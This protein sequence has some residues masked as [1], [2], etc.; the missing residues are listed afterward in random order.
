MRSTALW[1]ATRGTGVVALLL[2]TAVVLLG[3][4][5][6]FRWRS[7]RLPKFLVHGLHRNLTLLVLAFLAVHIVTAVVDT[8]A[9]IRIVDAVI[10][11][12]G[13]YRPF[14]L[15]LGAVA[16]DLLIALTA[17]SL[18]RARVGVRLWRGLH[19]LVGGERRRRAHDHRRRE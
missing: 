18:L 14:W 11:F 10:P 16:F 15:G 8:F 7:P 2:L 3:V 4:S 17:T 9:P 19:W 12:V 5:S 6:T 1:Y 13:A